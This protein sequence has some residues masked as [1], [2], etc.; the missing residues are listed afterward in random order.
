MR[1]T[2]D[3]GIL[4]GH[5]FRRIDHEYRHI[6]A[7]HSAYGTDDHIFFQ[8]FFDLILAAQSCRIDKDIFFIVALQ[9]CIHGISGGAGNIRYDQTLFPD[10][11]VDDRRFS[12]IRLS[13]DRYL[14]RI[15]LFR[16]RRSFREIGD[17]LIEKIAQSLPLRCRDRVRFIQPEVIKLID[18]RHHLFVA[19]HFIDNQ[20]NR[21]AGAAQH[22]GNL[23]VRIHESLPH[24]GHK[25]DHIGRID[26]DLCLLTH[27]G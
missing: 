21:F 19:V 23:A 10:Q 5:A 18:I 15:I 13:D 12:H 3:L 2:G 25:H 11:A 20:Y 1:D 24:I 7:L 14:W 17:H 8:F 6:T 9:S 4:L 27:L 22:I 26:R 16:F